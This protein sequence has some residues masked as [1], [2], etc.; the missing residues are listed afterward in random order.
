MYCNGA[1]D[2]GANNLKIVPDNSNEAKSAVGS[3]AAK[4][5]LYI[6][7]LLHGVH[8][9]GRVT[10]SGTPI[11]LVTTKPYMINYIK[12]GRVLEPDTT[13]AQSTTP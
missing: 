2:W 3:R 1:V 5:M 4:N 10:K 11:C 8:A 9:H 6:R 12:K 7:A 13:S